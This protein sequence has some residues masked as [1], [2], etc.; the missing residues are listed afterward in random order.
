[1]HIPI[2]EVELHDDISMV[3]RGA[4]VLAE[5]VI[6]VKSFLVTYRLSI[7][8]RHSIRGDDGER[9]YTVTVEKQ[10]NGMRTRAF[11]R[12]FTENYREAESL[13]HRLVTDAVLPEHLSDIEIR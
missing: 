3:T 2:R 11:L 4:V 5:S 12:D 6:R 9:Y 8:P 13:Y 7:E 1:M 10:K